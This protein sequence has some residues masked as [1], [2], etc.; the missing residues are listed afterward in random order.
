MW[1]SSAQSPAESN[2]HR[3]PKKAIP[4]LKGLAVGSTIALILAG[5]SRLHP[6]YLLPTV[7]PAAGKPGD[8]VT[9]TFHTP[10]SGN[11]HC[12]PDLTSWGLE[13]LESSVDYTRLELVARYSD[14]QLN[15][16]QNLDSPLPQ[17][18]LVQLHPA[19]AGQGKG[20][21]CPKPLNVQVPKP[22][23][24]TA[25]A[26]HLIFGVATSID[27]LEEALEAFA[28]WAGG[29][30]ARILA[31]VEP[32]TSEAR[33]KVQQKARD[34][35]INL[36]I[37]QSQA[38]WNDRYFGL[39]KFLFEERKDAQWASLIDDD[40]FFL[41]RTALVSRLASF[42][43]SRP[44]YLGGL[45]EDL[46][47][48]R[49]HGVMGFGGAGV[50]LSLPLLQQIYDHFDECQM[51]QGGGGDWRLAR[52][53]YQYTSA[54][55]TWEHDL[56]Q[57]DLR[58]DPSGM[59]EAGQ[60]QPLSLHHWKSWNHVDMV[61]LSAVST[62]S[63][64][65]AL[66]MRWRFADGWHLINGYS[67]VKYSDDYDITVS[68]SDGDSTSTMEKTWDDVL[69]AQAGEQE[70]HDAFLHSLGPL[71]PKDPG[72][73]SYHL[74]NVIFA[75]DGDDSVAQTRKSKTSKTSKTGTGDETKP[76]RQ[77]RQI[78]VRRDGPGKPVQGVVEVV[79]RTTA[80]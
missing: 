19:D 56:H 68:H 11:L 38:D 64:D 55:L 80:P 18:Q 73:I 32:A 2:R 45:S 52:C 37:R 61:K 78:Y 66:L 28:H 24:S 75:D 12:A 29:S 51:S 74:E 1:L 67:L 62:V 30:G 13:G 22:L 72:K 59:Y 39:V 48:I 31:L 58:G 35:K 42:D 23:H 41:S 46:G 3:I 53:I 40:T 43:S 70:S 8:T 44:H 76:K 60:W 71:Q 69:E 36:S 7:S 57:V 16:S 21:K 33:R 15:F 20:G 79:W 34:L 63:G 6:T 54:K 50:F 17:S 49:R 77:I 65:A 47:Q 14:E 9:P 27:R 5:L 4:A 26:S 10:S 25:D